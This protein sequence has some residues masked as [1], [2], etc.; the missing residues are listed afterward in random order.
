MDSLIRLLNLCH[1]VVYDVKVLT[2][3]GDFARIWLD[4]PPKNSQGVLAEKKICQ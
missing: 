4:S 1:T 2:D 3:D